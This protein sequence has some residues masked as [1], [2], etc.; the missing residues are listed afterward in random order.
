MHIRKFVLGLLL[1]VAAC[2]ESPVSLPE[3]TG[4][5]VAAA[6]MSMAVGDQAPLAA[7]V[8]DQDGKVMQGQAVVYSTDNASV[9]TVGADGMV[10]AVGPGTANVT[11]AHGGTAATVKVTV[12]APAQRVTVAGAA[13]GLV[14]GESAPVGAQVVDANGRVIPGAAPVFSSDNP[15]VATVSTD[16]V[17]RGVTPGTARITAAYGGSTAT[18]TV[19]VVGDQRNAVQSLEVMVDS[20]VTDWRAGVQ[21]V[22]IRAVNAFGQTVCPDLTLR[23]SDRS[24]VTARM[25]GPCRIEVDPNFTGEATITA[26]V[27]GRTDTF[28]VRVTSSGQIAFISARPTSDELVAGGTVSY[29]VKVLDQNS[30]PIA[31]QRVHFETSV[32]ALSSNSVVTGEDGTA[33]VQWQI[34]T[35]LRNLGQNHWIA[36]RVPLANGVLAWRDETVFIN[37]ASLTDI[38][39]YRGTGGS[40]TRLDANSITVPGW[41]SVTV[42]ASGLD[43]YGNIRATDFNFSITGGYNFWDCGGSNGTRH[44]SGIEY[45][46]YYRSPGT[47]TLTATAEGRQKSVQVIFT[48]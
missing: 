6:S 9:A 5:Q 25:A 3:A 36:Y 12:T 28:R 8:V 42:G 4:V 29:T 27:D 40:F 2:D 41:S 20:L 46:C 26:E 31:N 44:T 13:M 48:N 15:N 11:A 1:A 35:D 43:Q 16:G 22:A 14:A 24:I 7:Q 33:T 18:V 39:L 10:R 21:F 38:I 32:G 17:V 37:G 23:S 30:R 45:T 34:P 47:T 19:T